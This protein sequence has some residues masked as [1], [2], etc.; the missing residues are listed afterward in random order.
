M[1]RRVKTLSDQQEET[2]KDKLL[3]F[4]AQDVWIKKGG[5]IPVTRL[6]IDVLKG[7]YI[8]ETFPAITS[9]KE[10]QSAREIVLLFMPHIVYNRCS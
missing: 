8:R 3:K 1:N 5:S 2:L 6:L 4:S 7:D 9:L 10:L